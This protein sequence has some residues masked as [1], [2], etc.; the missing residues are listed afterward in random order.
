VRAE[1]DN[2]AVFPPC[3]SAQALRVFEQLDKRDTPRPQFN[4]KYARRRIMRAMAD[5]IRS[6][7]LAAAA[8]AAR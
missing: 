5:E 4:Q 3:D 1:I 8:N 2:A 6:L 7:A